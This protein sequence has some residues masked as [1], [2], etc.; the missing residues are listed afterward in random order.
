MRKMLVSERI[1]RYEA[2]VSD[3]S[4]TDVRVKSCLQGEI[5]RLKSAMAMWREFQ[6]IP[7]DPVTWRLKA[8]WGGFPE[9]ARYADVWNYFVREL[10]VCPVKTGG[11]IELYS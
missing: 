8:P 9:N 5:V 1:A 6:S 3:M 7:V 11:A 4:V 10:G 2:V